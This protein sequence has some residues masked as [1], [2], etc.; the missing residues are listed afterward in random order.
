MN[1]TKSIGLTASSLYKKSNRSII[2]IQVTE[3]AKAIDA[4]IQTAHQSGFNIIKYELPTNFSINNMEK[5][6]AQILIYSMILELY[7]KSE[8]NGGKGFSDVT[9]DPGP[10]TFIIVKWLNG[11]DV[12]EKN[13]RLKLIKDYSRKK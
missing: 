13:A 7:T 9:I 4:Q 6:D 2:D 1:V 3:Q 5:S 10:K 12:D 8:D 11:M